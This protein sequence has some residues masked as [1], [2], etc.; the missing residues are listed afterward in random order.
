MEHSARTQ[1]TPRLPDGVDLLATC[2]SHLTNYHTTSACRWIS[3]CSELPPPPKQLGPP[4]AHPWKEE[5]GPK[6]VTQAL[7]AAAGASC[8]KDSAAPSHPPLQGERD[9]CDAMGPL[10]KAAVGWMN[11]LGGPQTEQL[12]SDR[13]GSHSCNLATALAMRTHG[14]TVLPSRWFICWSS[15][16]V[17]SFAHLAWG[18]SRDGLFA[19][20]FF[21]C[22]CGKKRK[23]LSN[24]LEW[25]SMALFLWREGKDEHKEPKHSGCFVKK[26]KLTNHTFNYSKG[27]RSF[28]K[29]KKTTQIASLYLFFM[30]RDLKKT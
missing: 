10:G 18:G 8:K 7:A 2:R 17:Q 20:G 22:I 28:K 19:L 24:W 5:G 26:E 23:I 16:L 1:G 21:F 15:S 9:G 11:C 6:G 12:W 29:K 27:T 25:R 14:V 3:V 30:I 13:N 4:R